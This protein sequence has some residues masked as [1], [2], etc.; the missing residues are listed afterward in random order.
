MTSSPSANRDHS[1]QSRRPSSEQDVTYADGRFGVPVNLLPRDASENKIHHVLQDLK[2][3][4]DGNCVRLLL[5][6]LAVT[7]SPALM[8]AGGNIQAV[9]IFEARETRSAHAISHDN[10]ELGREANHGHS[11]GSPGGAMHMASARPAPIA[12]SRAPQVFGSFISRMRG[13]KA[14]RS[15]FGSGLSHNLPITALLAGLLLLALGWIAVLRRRLH[16]LTGT[17]L[18]RL[19]REIVLE[20][21][22][23]DLFENANDMVYTHDL[24][25]NLT[26]LNRVGE[27]ITGYD[28]NE[29]LKLNLSQ[30][31][32][33]E[34]LEAASRII[35]C[36]NAEG[37][38]TT[39]EIEIVARD[40]RRIP[41]EVSAR[42][43]Q[44]DGETEGVQCNARDV[45]ERKRAEA[46]MKRAKEAAEAASR[47]KGEFL[48]NVSHEIRTPM[49]GILGMTQLALETPL[50]SEQREYLNAVRS[51]ADSLMTVINDILDFSK[52]EAGKLE[53]ETIPFNL[54]EC[55][56]GVLDTLVVQADRKRLELYCV[57]DSQLPD[58][59]LGDPGRLR[60][61]LLNLAGNAIKF[62][63][64]G[65]VVI[66]V[67]PECETSETV[68]LHFC[69]RDTGI[70]I[71]KEKQAMVFESFTQADGSTTRK[72][73]GT[74]LGLAIS[75]QLVSMFGG[76]IW[77]DSEP[78]KGST[79]H[80]TAS[81]G[82]PEKSADLCE[83]Y[84][85]KAKALLSLV[86]ADDRA[87]QPMMVQPLRIILA[88]DNA[89]NQRV[90]S[91]ILQKRG[92]DVVV[93]SNGQEFLAALEIE[94]PGRY[95]VA[96][97]DVQMPEMDGLEAT[98]LLR[99]SEKRTGARLPIIA[100]TAHAM[101]G[102]R[103]LC[104][105]AGMDVY[106]AKPIRT[107]E[108]IAA[109]E[110]A[111]E[112]VYRAEANATEHAQKASSRAAE[113]FEARLVS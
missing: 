99:E 107:P 7:T 10:Q 77:L 97:V 62:T 96:I 27:R 28:R 70:G 14:L 19:H 23:R 47:A 65:E 45:T 91:R 15:L 76:R 104:L 84:P 73:G 54:R 75:A 31:V 42:T 52:I 25:G 113:A 24:A 34:C 57:F 38:T 36:R 22:Y 13:V 92:H 29:A 95:D 110:T 101:K 33:P 40:G 98:R 53:L 17:M 90:I 94:E 74:G 64:R 2:R 30:L 51:S 9:Q 39:F 109:V 80:F 82:L 108:L 72:F 37:C 61:I 21:Q 49:N 81:F 106:V 83:A 88:E 46:E 66:E 87:N 105:A 43:V 69:V 63:Q 3:R 32:A 78:E 35:D 103:E 71:P 111:A 100:V 112:P 12:E 93:V 68:L 85:E 5:A 18:G 20:E 56:D 55:V 48:A 67:R 50:D 44:R 8:I 26:S 1:Y 11:L 59:L 89:V 4:T 58:P 60:Q 16:D 41:L 6:L 86:A 79:F 102:D